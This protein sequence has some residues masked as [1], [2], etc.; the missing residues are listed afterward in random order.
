M[1]DIKNTDKI[2]LIILII[3]AFVSYAIGFIL[4]ENSAGGAVVDF[5]YVKRNIIT[6]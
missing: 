3:L 6:F 5:E 2:I 4:G 1:Q